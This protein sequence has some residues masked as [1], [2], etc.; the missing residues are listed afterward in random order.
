MYVHV[1]TCVFACGVW[2]WVWVWVWVC[3]CVHD[4]AQ[5]AECFDEALWRSEEHAQVLRDCSLLVGMHPDQA[6]EPLV[7]FAIGS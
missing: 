2:V 6:T 7:D 5:I 4:G 1:Y 3:G